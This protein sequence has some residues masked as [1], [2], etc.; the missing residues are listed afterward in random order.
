MHTI[1]TEIINDRFCEFIYV[2]S[3]DLFPSSKIGLAAFR[4]LFGRTLK[5][6]LITNRAD[7]FRGGV[8]P[9]RKELTPSRFLNHPM[10]ARRLDTPCKSGIARGK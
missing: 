7:R 2:V 3:L 6:Q 4:K 8:N 10:L 5:S 9:F 1:K